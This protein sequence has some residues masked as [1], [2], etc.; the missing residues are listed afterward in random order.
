MDIKLTF[1]GD[2][3]LDGN[4]VKY[5]DNYRTSDGKLD[6]HPVF[7]PMRELFDR[8]DYVLANLETPITRNEEEY[9][10]KQWEF[11]TPFEFAQALKDVGVDY[12]STANN[13][14]LDRGIDGL[15]ETVRCLD[16]IGFHHSGVDCP[17][18]G[19]KR[20][21]VDI[22]GLKLGI[23]SYTYGTNAKTNGQYL[24]LR[25]NRKLVNLIQ[26]QEGMLDRYDPF[27]WLIRRHPGGILERFRNRILRMI[28]PENTGKMWYE[29]TT[30]GTYRRYLLSR[31]LRDMRNL[32]AD[33][34]AINLHVGGQYNEEPNCLTKRTINWLRR[35]KC[36]IIVGNH[37]HVVH[38]CVHDLAYNQIATYAIGNFLGSAGTLHE[39]FDRYAE[40][41]IALHVY[42]DP[43]EKEL[44]RCT[45]S[46]LVSRCN[47]SGI[48]EVWPVKDLILKSTPEVALK[49][50]DGG[51]AVAKLFAGKEYDAIRD[52]FPLC[53]T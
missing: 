21:I 45:F 10:H 41:S 37:E 43:Q 2:V 30:I 15:I 8:A 11:G 48:F 5:L 9:T 1:V 46:V 12:V 33:L 28:W 19:K 16:Q 26:E 24:G 35:K 6:F 44:K 39:P 50:A 51:L 32:G 47:E 29:Q 4:M 7:E 42:I 18:T 31:E 40:Y 23:L 49:L 17:G 34:T 52:E 27:L 22:N 25:A 38:G 53:E 36:N 13:H 20:L 3:L 14:C